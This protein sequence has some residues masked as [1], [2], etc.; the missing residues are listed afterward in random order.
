M[1]IENNFRI[2]KSKVKDFL[3]ECLK[4]EHVS[5]V[6][7][8]DCS[9]SYHRQRIEGF[10]PIEALDNIMDGSFPFF[11]FIHREFSNYWEFCA[12]SFV[13]KVEYFLWIEVANKDA[14]NLLT[15]INS[16]LD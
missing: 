14:Y 1:K 3:A 12:S 6:E 11:T 16:Y 15:R 2:S 7:K 13:G 4:I 8:L 9:D 5:Y 10:T